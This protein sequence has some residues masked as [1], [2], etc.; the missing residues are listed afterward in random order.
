MPDLRDTI[1]TKMLEHIEGTVKA[2]GSLVREG[3]DFG[4]SQHNCKIWVANGSQVV[5]RSW[6]DKNYKKLG[7]LEISAAIVEE[8]AENDGDDW[9]AISFI[10]MRVGRLPHVPQ[11]WIIYCTNPDAPS[12]PA[13]EDFD[14]G[15][16]LAGG[17]GTDPLKHVYF[18]V[19]D[20]NPFL[21][22]SY[23]KKLK[24][25]L[26][27]KMYERMGRGRWI[28]ITSDVIYYAY[29][30]HNFVREDYKIDE[31]APIFITHDF[32]IGKGKPMS[33][34]AFQVIDNAVR[35]FREFIIE[36]ADTEEMMDEI[37]S[38]GLLDYDTDYYVCGDAT[39]ASK[40]TNSKKSD[41]DIIKRRLSTYRGPNGRISFD[42]KV[43]KANPGVRE[44]HNTVNGLCRSKS[45][46]VRL[47][48]Y[49]ACPTVNKGMRQTTLKKGG[50]YIEDDG[51]NH[52]YQ[53]VTTALG[54]A[55]HYLFKRKQN[56]AS[57]TEARVR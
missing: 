11:S 29:G 41:Y 15:D 45:G 35:V 34:C 39:G 13:Y 37:E 51:P 6:H 48:V 32:N 7:S 14:L 2:D 9:Q 49:K 46:H 4:F 16:W 27:A 56:T 55:C 42:F 38:S 52:P 5:S 22:R 20:E 23:I 43:P 47:F 28:E 25:T 44:R 24:D 1:F 33:A 26:D 12:H 21:P 19:T 17:T 54:Y 31:F 8:L 40:S 50:S 53:H 10:R 30:D 3:V 36:G 57:A 18:S